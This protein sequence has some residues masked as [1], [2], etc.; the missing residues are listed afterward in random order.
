MDSLSQKKISQEDGQGGRDSATLRPGGKFSTNREIAV[1]QADYMALAND[2]EQAQALAS[3]LEIQLSGKTNE[4]A[5]F[6]AIWERTQSDLVK[7]E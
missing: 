7:F 2:L 4:L 6:K 1:V 3:S 5:R